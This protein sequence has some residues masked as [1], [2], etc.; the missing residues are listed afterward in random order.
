MDGVFR[1]VTSQNGRIVR[2]IIGVILIV[3]GLV[4]ALNNDQSWGWIIAVIG[5]FPLGAG[6]FDLCLFAPLFGRSYRG[7]EVRADLARKS[8]K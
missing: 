6:V 3:I 5:L 7:A 4:L 2:A 1:F 8:T